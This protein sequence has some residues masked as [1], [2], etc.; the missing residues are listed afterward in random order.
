MLWDI[1]SQCETSQ[2]MTDRH[3]TRATQTLQK[4]HR[5][6]KI[7]QSVTTESEITDWGIMRSPVRISTLSDTEKM[8]I[9]LLGFKYKKFQIRIS[10]YQMLQHVGLLEDTGS[11]QDPHELICEAITK[12]TINMWVEKGLHFFCNENS[13]ENK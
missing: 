9:D 6:M 13:K 8:L 3:G 12:Q 11:D 10:L 7:S 2:L 1:M 5:N 4:A